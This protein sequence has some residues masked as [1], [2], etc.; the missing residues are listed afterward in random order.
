MVMET[1]GGLVYSVLFDR[2]VMCSV[3]DRIAWHG[4]WQ[5]VEVRWAADFDEEFDRLAQ[6]TAA[7]ARSQ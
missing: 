3:A 2:P 6:H 7:Q 1:A 5:Q 4:S